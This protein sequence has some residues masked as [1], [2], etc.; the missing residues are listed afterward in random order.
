MTLRHQ[1]R[2][3]Y[4]SAAAD[5]QAGVVVGV[6]NQVDPQVVR[7]DDRHSWGILRVVVFFG[8]L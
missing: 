8:H 3:N 1:D 4:G 2:V 5:H 7:G 6:T